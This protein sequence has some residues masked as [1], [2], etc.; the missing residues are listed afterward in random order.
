MDDQHLQQQRQT[1]RRQALQRRAG[2][3]LAAGAEAGEGLKRHGLQLIASLTRHTTTMPVVAGYV[4]VRGEIDVMPLLHA[5]HGRGH[6]IVLP[7]VARKD[8][9]LVFRRW[10][11]GMALQQGRFGIAVPP[12]HAPRLAP[13]ILLVPL[14]AF[15]RAGHRLGYGGGYYDR[16]LAAMHT[17]AQQHDTAPPAA[18]GCAFAGQEL[19]RIPVLPTDKRLDFILTERGIIRPMAGQ[20]GGS[21]PGGAEGD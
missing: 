17:R 9:P 15:A 1:L 19:A 8:A 6:E 14:A 4:P 11:P 16:T 7:V 18:I 21:T 12:D 10:Q 5:L 20:T 2:L 3:A 13:D